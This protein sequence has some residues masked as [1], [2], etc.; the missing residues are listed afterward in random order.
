MRAAQAAFDAIAD[1]GTVSDPERMMYFGPVA[2]AAREFRMVFDPAIVVLA[3]CASSTMA[4]GLGVRWLERQSCDVVLVGGYDEVGTLVAAGFESLRVITARAPPRPFRVGRDGTVLGEGAAAIALARRS[5]SS[6]GFVLG[7][8]AT[9]D[10]GHLTAPDR[11]GLGL[12][13]AATLALAEARASNVDLVSVHGSATPF[14]DASE[15][16][17]LQKALGGPSARLAV[18]HPFK[19]Q[20]GHTMGASGALELLTCVDAIRRGVLPAAAGDGELDPDAPA[21]ML[22]VTQ[23]GT[24]RVALKLS[25][26]FGGSNAAIVVAGES[27]FAAPRSRRPAYVVRAV[28]RALSVPRGELATALRMPI[29]RIVRADELVRLALSSVLLLQVSHGS[30]RGAGLVVGTPLAT[31]ETN[32]LFAKQMREHG[33]RSVW[34]RLFPY[35]SPNAVAGEVSSAFGLTGPCFSVGGGLHAGLE[36]LAAAAVLV[37][38]GDAERM[39]VV[40]VDDAGPVTEMLAGGTL[41]SGSV[42]SLVQRDPSGAFARVADISLRRGV[43]ARGDGTAGHKALMPLTLPRP[44]STLECSSP[45][46]ADASITFES[47]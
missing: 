33:A 13:R 29:E 17:A 47:L 22:E 11:Q 40:A 34:P 4:V 2:A 21:R 19:A 9:S 30:L 14:S 20:I 15:A 31:L 37:E 45:P 5:P 35:T 7:F 46:D 18:V 27:A 10:S 38:S 26:A 28:H 3:A 44:P 42:A 16:L 8:G 24:P 32:A 1:G 36:A 39:V 23:P 6:L 43:V 12:A 25:S 41:T